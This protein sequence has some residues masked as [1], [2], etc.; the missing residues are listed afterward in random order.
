MYEPMFIF[1]NFIQNAEN[2]DEIRKFERSVL[3]GNI[4][5]E[6]KMQDNNDEDVYTNKQKNIQ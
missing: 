5:K 2:L 6:L 4:E 3:A 1:Q